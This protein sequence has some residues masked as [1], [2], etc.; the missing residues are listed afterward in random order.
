MPQ[1]YQKYLTDASM[2][3]VLMNSTLACRLNYDIS[4]IIKQLLHEPFSAGSE[5]NIQILEKRFTGS[6]TTRTEMVWSVLENNVCCVY[7]EEFYSE[8]SY[9]FQINQNICS[10]RRTRTKLYPEKSHK[11][12]VKI[13]GKS[14]TL[15][16]K[17][18]WFPISLRIPL[19]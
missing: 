1:K 9:R 11:S 5:P 13:Q 2:G 18:R 4:Q 3:N 16:R 6:R 19:S 10:L 12:G 14:N 7:I 8:M 15:R 17:K